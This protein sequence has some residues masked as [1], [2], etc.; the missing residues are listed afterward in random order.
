MQ[1]V[2]FGTNALTL[3]ALA[4]QIN[5]R[6]EII[7]AVRSQVEDKLRQ[8]APEIVLQGQALIAAKARV[9]FGEWLTWLKAHCP[10]V[11]KRNAQRYMARA[12]NATLT[13]YYHL[14]CDGEEPAAVHH[15]KQWLP[16]VEALTKVSRFQAY[17]TR[18]P[19]HNWPEPGR[20]RLKEVLEPIARELWPQQFKSEAAAPGPRQ[21]QPPPHSK[22]S[23]MVS[24]R[25]GYQAP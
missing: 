24:S 14:L 12:E 19:I 11:S 13:D 5:E 2:T 21:A 6:E 7:D 10:K 22:A 8:A 15:N 25:T 23:A 3:L 4:K 20:E 17:I 1:S 16:Y 9:P 18:F